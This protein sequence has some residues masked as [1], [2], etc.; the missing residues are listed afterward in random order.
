MKK[1][2]MKIC[3][4]SS[5]EQVFGVITDMLDYSWRSD[6]SNVEFVDVGKYIEFNRKN[7]PTKIA[8]TECIEN[9]QF[10]YDVQNENYTGHWCGQFA[11]LDDGGC[12]M[13]LLFYFESNSFLGNFL[14]IEK[15]EK[16]YIDDLKKKLG[17]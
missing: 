4:K 14:N 16:R 12:I 15:F 7:H 11:P 13:Y 3:F 2:E 1:V 8:V 6:L 10:E 17:E 5:V 9:T